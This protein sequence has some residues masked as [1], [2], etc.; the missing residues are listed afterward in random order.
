MQNEL[1]TITQEKPKD[2]EKTVSGYSWQQD[3]IERNEQIDWTQ[4]YWKRTIAERIKQEFDKYLLNNAEDGFRSHLGWSIIGHPCLRYLW[5]NFHWFKQETHSARMLEIFNEGHREEAKIR[6]LMIKCGATF[7]D[8]VDVDGKQ[9]KVSDLNGHFGGSCDGVFMWPAMGI[10]EPCVLECKTSKQ[11]TEFNNLMEH[12][13][14]VS[15]EKQQ[16]HAQ[17]NGYAVSLEI[18][19][20]LYACRN[21]ND[22]RLYTEILEAEPALVAELRNK[23]WHIITTRQAPPKISK[24]RNYYICNMC[25]MQP[26]CHDNEQIVPN[27][28]NCQY[29]TPIENG[30]WK[31][32]HHQAIIPKEFWIKGCN[33]HK[34]MEY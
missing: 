34:Q 1:V 17:A 9:I 20:I 6:A 31:C 15:S 8:T 22:S 27:C 24:K 3:A 30:Q 11:N 28:R 25:T 14:T 26:V 2:V 33:Q 5:F 12:K 13:G 19:I 23:A 29:S 7:L 10:T 4:A 16:H 32:E 18:R 21:K